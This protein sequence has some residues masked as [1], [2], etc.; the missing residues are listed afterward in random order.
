[1]D[2]KGRAI[3]RGQSRPEPKLGGKKLEKKSPAQALERCG[4]VRTLCVSVVEERR[5]KKKVE[6][7]GKGTRKEFVSPVEEVGRRGGPG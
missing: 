2:E 3:G 5:R 4:N 1:M 6:G 7:S